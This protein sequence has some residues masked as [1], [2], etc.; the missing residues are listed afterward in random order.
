MAAWEKGGNNYSFD[1]NYDWDIPMKK[2]WKFRFYFLPTPKFCLV[3]WVGIGQCIRSRETYMYFWIQIL[4]IGYQ[5]MAI[6]N[7][8]YCDGFY[9]LV[10]VMDSF[11]WRVWKFSFGD[12]LVILS[13]K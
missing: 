13:N 10:N 7:V 3:K 4:Q 2:T 9:E 8:R 11:I 6:Y 12:L 5:D 1:A